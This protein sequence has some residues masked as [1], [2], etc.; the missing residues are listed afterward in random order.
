MGDFL[1]IPHMRSVLLIHCCVDI[2]M[3]TGQHMDRNYQKNFPRDD[4]CD[5]CVFL[6]ASLYIAFNW[7]YINNNIRLIINRIER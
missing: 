3:N 1:S 4:I 7:D 6:Y 2:L 5:P